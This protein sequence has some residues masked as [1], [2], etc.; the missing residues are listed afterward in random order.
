MALVFDLR[1][2]EWP[3]EPM[4]RAFAAIRCG[5][6]RLGD[7]VKVYDEDKKSKWSWLEFSIPLPEFMRGKTAASPDLRLDCIHGE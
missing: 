6:L 1:F 3:D 5:R 4:G 7:I 2:G